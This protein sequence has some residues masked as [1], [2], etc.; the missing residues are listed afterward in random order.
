MS[1]DYPRIVIIGLG[2][3]GLH[4]IRSAQKQDRNVD[5]TVIERRSYDMFSPCGL[6]YAVGKMVE[7]F[8]ALKHTIPTTRRMKKL[9]RHEARKID[10]ASR[11]VEVE[12]LDTGEQKMIEYDRLIVA[13]G[14]RPTRLD[15]PG[16]EALW[17][18]GIHVVSNPENARALQEHAMRS[19]RAVVIGGGAIGLEIASALK[20]LGLDVIVTKKSLPPFPRNLDPDMGEIVAEYLNSQGCRLLFGQDVESING[21]DKVESVTIGG[22]VIP[23][24]IVVMALGVE[25]ES[26]LAAEAGL[27]IVGGA[28]WTNER[29]ETSI[30]GVYAVGECAQTFSGV[31]GSKIKIDLATTAFRQAV[32]AGTNAAGGSQTF[33]GALGTFVSHIGKLEVAS[34]GLNS[35]A[36]ESKRMKVITGRARLGGKPKWMPDSKDVTVKV[37]AEAG[38]GRILGGQ[39][40][41]EDGASWR[42]NMIAQALRTRMTLQEFSSLELAYC[43]AVSE[44]YDPLLAAVD[45]ALQRAK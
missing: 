23:T 8:E 6:P 2:T 44:L 24:D 20:R 41:G 43:P 28:V 32:V 14:S 21:T 16:A 13:T 40:I 31:D 38:T 27:R 30:T 39:A 26:R 45:V 11:V 36:A 10:V 33:P 25:P 42:V 35:A 37:V 29:M 34:T 12:D 3:G 18:K 15:I 19:K 17:S 9:L 5:I 7:S 22:D 4:A 1:G